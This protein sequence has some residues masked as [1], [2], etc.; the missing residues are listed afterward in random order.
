MSEAPL[1][2]LAL[3]IES[4]KPIRLLAVVG[5]A[6]LGAVLTGLVVAAIVKLAFGQKVPP[7][8]AWVVRVL[9]GCLFGFLVYLWLFGGGGG[10]IGGPGGWFGGS[11]KDGARNRDGATEPQKDKDRQAK[12]EKD[13]EKEK[14]D[15]EK[16]KDGKSG[17]PAG[18]SLQV[19]VLGPGALKKIARSDTFDPA[20]CYRVKGETQLLTLEQL[21]KLI[22]LRRMSLSG[23]GKLEIFVYLDSPAMDKPQVAGLESWA[24]EPDPQRGKLE[25]ELRAPDHNAPVD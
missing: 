18:P 24:R 22:Q 4:D 12:K 25:V 15:K 3:L 17:A 20:R 21:R 13:R 8:P 6:A 1:V 5:A 16:D 7:W 10:G 11:G 14:K 23:L 9:G 19:E 2:L